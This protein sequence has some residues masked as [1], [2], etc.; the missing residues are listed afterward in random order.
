MVGCKFNIVPGLVSLS[1]VPEL[2]RPVVDVWYF[3][4]EKR[5]VMDW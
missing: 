4:K 3:E 5:V 1:L 2:D